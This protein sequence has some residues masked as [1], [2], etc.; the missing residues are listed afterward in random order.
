MELNQFLFPAPIPSYTSSAFIGEI[1]YVPKYARDPETNEVKQFA[2]SSPADTNVSR[3]IEKSVSASPNQQPEGVRRSQSPA[4]V[5][6]AAGEA[7]PFTK[8]ELALMSIRD[9]AVKAPAAAGSANEER[10]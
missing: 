9:E 5:K 3:V 4:D 2:D 7:P 1:I 10:K 6:N 8:E